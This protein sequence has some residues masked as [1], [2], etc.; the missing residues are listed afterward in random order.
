MIRINITILDNF[1][2]IENTILN[3]I[4]I[5]I[6]IAGTGNS[7]NNSNE[8]SSN[9]ITIIQNYFLNLSFFAKKYIY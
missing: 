8:N 4:P 9:I 6:I 3:T 1:L 5:S 7:E 2:I